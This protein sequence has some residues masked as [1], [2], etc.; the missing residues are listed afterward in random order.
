MLSGMGV[1]SSRRSLT[2]DAAEPPLKDAPQPDA[3]LL[4][5]A[6]WLLPFFLL[7]LF[8]PCTFRVVS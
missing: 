1:K 3:L 5:F 6:A 4:L 2:L 8:L 7:A